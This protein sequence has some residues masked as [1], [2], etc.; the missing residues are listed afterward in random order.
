MA[1]KSG[2]LRRLLAGGSTPDSIMADIG[3]TLARLFAGFSMAL[4]HGWGK[5]PPSERFIASVGEMGFPAPSLFAWAAA[6][7]E[8]VGGLL[9]ALGLA[10]RLGA[11]SIMI[12]MGVA[13]FIRHAPDPYARKEMALLYLAIA[14]AY[15]F[16]G[17]GRFSLDRFI[18]GR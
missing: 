7:S 3:L 17:A 11:L 16:A 2:K 12:T 18:R 5:L 6:L 9:L 13:A 15:F 10:T 4:A 1:G 8:F 14:A